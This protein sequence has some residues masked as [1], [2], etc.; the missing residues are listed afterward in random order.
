MALWP[1]G[2]TQSVLGTFFWP[3]VDCI[4]GVAKNSMQNQNKACFWTMDSF[5]VN[6]EALKDALAPQGVVISDTSVPG[7]SAG[8][9]GLLSVTLSNTATVYT[10]LGS[11]DN[12]LTDENGKRIPMAAGYFSFW[13]LMRN[14][15]LHKQIDVSIT[16][17]DNPSVSFN[18]VS[19]HLGNE[20]ARIPGERFYS[21]YLSAILERD[22]SEPIFDTI[23][24]WGI[25]ALPSL[26]TDAGARK[27]LSNLK[28]P[29]PSS[30]HD[31][32]ASRSYRR[33]K[34]SIRVSSRRTLFF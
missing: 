19:F 2:L 20:S 27:R 7:A 26:E 16:G 18:D 33:L 1:K 21:A 32:D 6:Q 30:R 24:A 12:Y 5:W 11:P 28:N 25:Y 34:R 14:A 3:S 15:S 23:N 4:D 8:G 29:P 10:A 31:R 9:N 13:D 22:F 17:W